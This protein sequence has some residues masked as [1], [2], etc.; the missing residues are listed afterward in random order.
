AALAQL[1][2]RILYPAAPHLLAE[3][4]LAAGKS[5]GKLGQPDAAGRVFRELI[6]GFPATPAAAEAQQRLEA[7]NLN[8]EKPT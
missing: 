6:A 5:L 2:V 8:S 3:S 7:I 1:Q 4:L